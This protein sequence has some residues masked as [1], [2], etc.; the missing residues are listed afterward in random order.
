MFFKVFPF[1]YI[2]RPFVF[3]ILFAS[4]LASLFG[5]FLLPNP[6]KTSLRNNSECLLPGLQQMIQLKLLCMLKLSSLL[7]DKELAKKQLKSK[8]TALAANPV[9]LFPKVYDYPLFL[10]MLSNL[11]R[12]MNFEF[13]KKRIDVVEYVDKRF[14]I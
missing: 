9:L 4:I 10:S 14:D 1:F 13:P 8:D 12:R 7:R 11:K 2:F 6:S 3:C 5:Q